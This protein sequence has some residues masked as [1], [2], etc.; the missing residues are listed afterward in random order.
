MSRNAVYYPETTIRDINTLKEALFLWD[1]VDCIVPIKRDWND[2]WHISGELKNQYNEAT[3]LLLSYK[4]PTHA[5]KKLAHELILELATSNVPEEYLLD[6]GTLK[7]DSFEIYG[8][9]FL[10]ETFEALN[11]TKLATR[12]TGNWGFHPEVGLAVMSIIAQV[13][14]GSEKKV[15]TDYSHADRARKKLLSPLKTNN[16]NLVLDNELTAFTIAIDHYD[17]S[18]VDFGKLLNLRKREL[19]SNEGI[20]IRQLRRNYSTHVENS[21]IRAC[22][23]LTEGQ[24]KVDIEEQLSREASEMKGELAEA[25]K[26]ESLDTITT[27]PFLLTIGAALSTIAPAITKYGWVVPPIALYSGARE[28]RRKRR[29]IMSTN[30]FAWLYRVDE[31]QLA[32]AAYRFKMY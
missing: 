6:Q 23:L 26:I 21:A 3:D 25:L 10:H 28:Y 13:C 14:A 5:Q 1:K 8:E 12:K 15:L 18:R 4:V 29:E 11:Q 27:K 16:S 24:D 22:K 32:N 30:P 19:S 17:F 31:G 2:D 9:K 7:N 20:Q